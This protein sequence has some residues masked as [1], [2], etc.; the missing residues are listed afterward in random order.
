MTSNYN[1]IHIS[2]TPER[3]PYMEG[4]IFHAPECCSMKILRFDG[5]EVRRV[6]PNVQK[7]IC[8]GT[9]LHFDYDEWESAI[10]VLPMPKKKLLRKSSFVY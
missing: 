1:E 6:S 2:V 9:K 10:P 5:L 7:G 3:C 8:F 4:D